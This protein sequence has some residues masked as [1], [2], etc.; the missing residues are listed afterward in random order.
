MDIDINFNFY[1]DTPKS[2]DPDSYSPTLRSY[3]KILWSRELPSGSLFKL[4]ESIPMRLHHKSELGEFVLSS[5]SIAHT[6]SNIK[7]TTD[8][9][10][11]INADELEKFVSLCS[12]IGGYII[13]PSERINNQMTINGARGVNK[14]IRDRFDL[15]L[16]C[17]RKY[18]KK[19]DSPLI[20]TF[21]RYKQFFNLFDSFK[22]YVDFFLLQ[23]LVTSDYSSIKYLIPFESFENYPLP[24][25]IEEYQLYKYNLSNF[26]SARSQRMKDINK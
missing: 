2:K 17:I 13:F 7:S 16:E 5:D 25:D 21:E 26:V 6:Y 10:K 9:I 18:Y 24:N 1:S 23:D 19:E 22:E 20:K 4:D 15:T 12:T 3:H 8:I 11:K 14:K